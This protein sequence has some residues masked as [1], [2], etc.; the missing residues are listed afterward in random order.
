[1]SSF[2]TSLHGQPFQCHMPLKSY[3]CQK[4]AKCV[5]SDNIYLPFNTSATKVDFAIFNDNQQVYSRVKPLLISI[6]SHSNAR[7]LIR[8][9]LNL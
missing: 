5:V 9:R 1:M 8:D 7:H 6:F 3:F 4:K 2:T